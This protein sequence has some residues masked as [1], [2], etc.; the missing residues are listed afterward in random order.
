VLPED[1]ANQSIPFATIDAVIVAKQRNFTMGS[2]AASREAP[3][4]D[5]HGLRCARVKV[6]WS[7][8]HGLRPVRVAELTGGAREAYAEFI[9]RRAH[10][11]HPDAVAC[12]SL[13]LRRQWIKRS[14]PSSLTRC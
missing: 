8:W 2:Q 14:L 10:L 4:L 1:T 6:V 12:F 7:D 11:R 3:R 13:I 9:T 5:C